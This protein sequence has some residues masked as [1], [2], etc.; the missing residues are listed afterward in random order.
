MA[1]TAERRS[2]YGATI[3]KKRVEFFCTEHCATVAGWPYEIGN[4][5]GER[6]EVCAVCWA[7]PRVPPMKPLFLDCDWCR[8][9]E[10]ARWQPPAPEDEIMAGVVDRLMGRASA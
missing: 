5:P 9:A 2:A 6:R 1:I 7:A 3:G 10:L 4:S 8:E